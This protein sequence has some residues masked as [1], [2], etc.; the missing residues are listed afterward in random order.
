VEGGSENRN[1]TVKVIKERNKTTEQQN[2]TVITHTVTT[3]RGTATF[4]GQLQYSCG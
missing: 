4:Y 3:E 1:N 2:N